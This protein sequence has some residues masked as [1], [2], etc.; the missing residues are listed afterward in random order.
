MKVISGFYLWF[1]I[2]GIF[3]KWSLNERGEKKKYRGKL[4]PTAPVLDDGEDADQPQP[5]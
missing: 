1:I 5:V 2:A 4:V 3:F